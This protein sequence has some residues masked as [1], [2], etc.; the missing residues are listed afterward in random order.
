M[1]KAQTND[2]VVEKELR[3]LIEF[4]SRLEYELG[5]V[6]GESSLV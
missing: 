1:K 2:V 5:E 6:V 3:E 4:T